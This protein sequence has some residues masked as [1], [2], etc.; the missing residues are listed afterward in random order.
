MVDE[1][2]VQPADGVTIEDEE[3]GMEEPSLVRKH[4]KKSDASKGKG[5]MSE[6]AIPSEDDEEVEKAKEEK[7]PL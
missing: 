4:S 7:R 3:A 1:E 2:E 6:K 5:K